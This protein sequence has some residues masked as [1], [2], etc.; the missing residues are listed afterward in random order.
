[1][2]RWIYLPVFIALIGTSTV[3]WS[4]NRNGKSVSSSTGFQFPSPEIPIPRNARSTQE[5]FDATRLWL[6]QYTQQFINQFLVLNGLKENLFNVREILARANKEVDSI[7]PNE[8]DNPTKMLERMTLYRNSLMALADRLYAK[9]R[10]NEAHFSGGNRLDS[11]ERRVSELSS[12]NEQIGEI[13]QKLES[14]GQRLSAV[15]QRKLPS[16]MPGTT[17]ISE[18]EGHSNKLGFAALILAAGSFFFQFYSKRK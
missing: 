4:A 6:A 15:E 12:L 3:G 1:M 5:K 10:P 8:I 13:T 14:F 16:A 7:P 11:L 9:D 2:K 18:G 17:V